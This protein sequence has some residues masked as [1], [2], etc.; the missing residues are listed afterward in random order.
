MMLL[1][2]GAVQF[3]FP[4]SL[5]SSLTPFIFWLFYFLGFILGSVGMYSRAA[6]CGSG[7]QVHY[8]CQIGLLVRL[9]LQTRGVRLW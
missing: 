7:M 5:L 4:S 8:G 6:V 3:F 2:L 9:T 1:A